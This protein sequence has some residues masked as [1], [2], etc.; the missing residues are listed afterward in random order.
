MHLVSKHYPGFPLTT[1]PPLASVFLHCLGAGLHQSPCSHPALVEK[2]T[3]GSMQNQSAK[4]SM[5]LI[6]PQRQSGC[7]AGG[8]TKEVRALVP[9]TCITLSVRVSPYEDSTGLRNESQAIRGHGLAT[10]ITCCSQVHPFTEPPDLPAQQLAAL[11]CL[12]MCWKRSLNTLHTWLQ[13]KIQDA[14][15]GNWVVFH[16]CYSYIFNDFRNSTMPQTLY[17]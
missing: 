3:Q 4:A 11:T 14:L 16:C 6:N 15:K 12:D 7:W 17:I 5:L 13:S 10:V 2:I 8:Q 1:P 9:I